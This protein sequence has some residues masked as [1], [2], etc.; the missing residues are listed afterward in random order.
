MSAGTYPGDE[1]NREMRHK[2]KKSWRERER[3]SEV[4]T[5]SRRER[6]GVRMHW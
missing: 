1:G 2:R 3:D 5:A 4:E 6:R